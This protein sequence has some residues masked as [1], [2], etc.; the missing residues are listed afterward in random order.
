MKAFVKFGLVCSLSVFGAASLVI[1]TTVAVV[2]HNNYRGMGGLETPGIPDLNMDFYADLSERFP[3][4]EETLASS[5]ILADLTDI[6]DAP[7]VEPVEVVEESEELAEVDVS[8]L[9]RGFEDELPV[10]SLLSEIEEETE[11]AVAE[12]QVDPTEDNV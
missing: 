12:V 8:E 1:G 6:S 5:V 11:P 2:H 4:Q 10:E 9:G 7:A 3:E